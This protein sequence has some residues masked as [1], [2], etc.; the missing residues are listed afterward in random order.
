MADG[1]L[2]LDEYG[3]LVIGAGG[4]PALVEG[5]DTLVQDIRHRLMTVKGSL[6]AD[7]EYGGDLPLYLH[8]EGRASNLRGMVSAL[9]EELKKETRIL[10]QRTQITPLQFVRAQDLTPGSLEVAL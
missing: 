3:D 7:A 6:P 5:M 1:D 9:S 10:P 4:E 8:Q 2:Q